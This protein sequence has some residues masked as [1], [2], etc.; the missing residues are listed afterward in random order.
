ME[1]R[2]ERSEENVSF[3]LEKR[4]P[5]LP[6]PKLARDCDSVGSQKSCCAHPFRCQSESLFTEGRVSMKFCGGGGRHESRSYEP[7][8]C[9]SSNPE[10][11]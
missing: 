4:V 1:R 8:V 2:V 6:L 7:S 5:H 9:V 11:N 10:L 3:G